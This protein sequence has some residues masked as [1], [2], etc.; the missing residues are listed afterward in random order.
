MEILGLLPHTILAG[1]GK[2]TFDTPLARSLV[3]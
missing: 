3:A 2:A 1:I